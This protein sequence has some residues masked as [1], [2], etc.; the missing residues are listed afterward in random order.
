MRCGSSGKAPAL[1]ARS[2]EFKPQSHQKTIL[3]HSTI[4]TTWNLYN[5]V[6]FPQESDQL[7]QTTVLSDELTV[8]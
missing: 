6:K 3:P 8:Q 7:G 1:Q 4:A 2:P 5:V